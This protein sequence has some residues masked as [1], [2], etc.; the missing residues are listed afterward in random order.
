[1]RFLACLRK[2]LE[3]FIFLS[4]PASFAMLFRLSNATV[5]KA[6]A[7]RR[8]PARARLAFPFHKPLKESR[9]FLFAYHVHVLS[10]PFARITLI[11]QEELQA[12]PIVS[13][14]DCPGHDRD[15]SF[16]DLLPVACFLQGHKNQ[17]SWKPALFRYQI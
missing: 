12:H 2:P 15:R 17:G 3:V 13:P 4:L 11:E 1:M 8:S 10:Q 5:S 9:E 6:L 16:G 14:P 7:D